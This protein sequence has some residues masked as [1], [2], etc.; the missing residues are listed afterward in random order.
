[1]TGVAITGWALRTPLGDTPDVVLARLLGGEHGATGERGGLLAPVR[2]EPGKSRHR[3]FLP[4]MALLGMDVA[5]EAAAHSGLGGGDGDRVGVF[6]GVG[7]LHGYWAE[8]RPALAGQDNGGGTWQR[9]FR[10]LHPFWL[11]RRL[12]NN[13]HALFAAEIEAHGEGMTFGGR[14]AGGQALVCAQHALEEGAVDVAVVMAYDSLCEPESAPEL[15][16]RGMTTSARVSDLRGPYDDGAGGFVPGE[17]AAAVVL[18]LPGRAGERGLGRIEASVAADG[19]RAEPAAATVGRVAGRISRGEAIVDGVGLANPAFDRAE[20]EAV[21]AVLGPRAWLLS[22]SA[23]LGQVGA[24]TAILQAIVLTE[25]LRCGTVPPIAALKRPSPG[26][27]D[28]GLH[29]RAT[30]DRAVLGVSASPPGLA[31]AVRVELP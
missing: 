1:M 31:C 26:P 23:S 27:L 4:R 25:I 17:A 15:A 28:P 20:R 3:R 7:G 14:N 9:G 29:P 13:A 24:P 5:L 18:E 30:S 22:T 2:S 8:T 12:S 16:M 10:L 19:D 11:L 21:G 6:A